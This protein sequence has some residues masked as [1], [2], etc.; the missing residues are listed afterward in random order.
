MDKG[1][2]VD[3]DDD[4]ALICAINQD[5]ALGF[6]CA[7][8]AKNVVSNLV[9]SCYCIDISGALVAPGGL[10]FLICQAAK[11]LLNCLDKH[12]PAGTCWT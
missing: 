7:R 6:D 3:C 4:F 5:G 12:D 1:L 9:A 10:M 2:P 11:Q 8:S